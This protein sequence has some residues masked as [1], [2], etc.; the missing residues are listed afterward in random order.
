M[1]YTLLKYSNK[2][3]FSYIV[4]IVY[5]SGKTWLKWTVLKL[6]LDYLGL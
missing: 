6:Y 5:K 3:V 2:K 1:I 4:S